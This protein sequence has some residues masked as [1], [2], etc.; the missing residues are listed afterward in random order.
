MNKNNKI[1]AIICAIL[2]AVFYALN[3]PFSKV[4]LKNISPTFMAS[5]L[6][7]GAGIGV[8]IMYLF[9]YK[10]EDKD[11]RLTKNDLTYTILM[12]V[13]DV[14][15]PIFL[16]IGISIGSSANA[17]L[18]GNFEI[19][20]TSIIALVFFKEDVSKNLWIAIVFI[21][22][23]SIILSFEGQESFRFSYGSLFV[24]LATMSWGLENNCTRKISNKSS[25]QIVTIK[26]LCSGIASLII[27]II[28][29][30]KFPEIRYTFFAL[31]LGYVAYGLSIFL[32]VRSQRDLGAAK[33]SA[34]YAIAPFIGTFLC[35]LVNGEALSASY[36]VGLILMIVGTV[37]VVIDTCLIKHTHLHTHTITHTHDG[38]THTHVLTH[39]HEH[40]H[41]LNED[42]EGHNDFLSS[43]EHMRLHKNNL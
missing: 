31:L 17:S 19:V 15:A 28:I 18:L 33:T 35:F 3:T 14:I 42:K 7:L 27:S 13:L 24:I 30:E 12:V 16:M 2:A 41:F 5:F 40:K 6:Y 11:M 22:L 4:L 39:E 20:A 37:F 43:E 34:Y 36:F 32:Y 10:N 26:G 8:G 29:G 38:Y 1:T 9:K 21:T 23:S 25:Y